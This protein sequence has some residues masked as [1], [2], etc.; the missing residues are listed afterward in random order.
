MIHL[1]LQLPVLKSFRKIHHLPKSMS[2]GEGGEIRVPVARS[3]DLLGR[4]VSFI[5]EGRIRG[6]R[7]RRDLQVRRVIRLILLEVKGTTEDRLGDKKRSAQTVL[8]LL[9][10]EYRSELAL[11]VL[12]L[13]SSIHFP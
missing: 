8:H 13:K 10:L 9:P 4:L 11:I 12:P 1:H 7:K 5:E 3:R 2:I 6:K